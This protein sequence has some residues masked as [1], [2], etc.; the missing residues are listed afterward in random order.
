MLTSL[1][2]AK[3][4]FPQVRSNLVARPRLVQILEKGL[5]GPLTLISAPAGSGKTTLMGEWRTHSEHTT[6]I[7]WL[8]LDSAENDLHRFLTYLT[9][10][11]QS[12]AST[13]TLPTNDLL[14]S[15]QPPPPD[16][17]AALLLEAL[18]TLDTDLVLALDDYH[19]ISNITIHE[20]LNKLLECAPPV[21]HLVILTRSDPPLPL[22]R[23]R[24]RNQ[25]TEIRAH[26]LRFT[27]D[28]SAE[29][30]SHIMGLS[31][32]S[33]QVAL[34][35]ERTEGWIAG[36]QLA[37]LS[38]RGREDVDDFV[39]AFAGSNRFVVDYLIEEVLSLQSEKTREFLLKTS[40]LERMSASLCN[41]LTGGSDGQSVLEELERAN[42]FVVNLGGDGQWYRYHHLFADLLRNR[43][44]AGHPEM[45]RTLH[46]HAVVWFDDHKLINEAIEHAFE[47]ENYEAVRQLMR[48][49]FPDWWRVENRVRVLQWFEKFP[50]DFLSNEPWLCVVQAWTMW[51]QGK[52]DKTEAILDRAQQ[53]VTR[54]QTAGQFPVGDLEYDGL[55]AEI[56]AF[57]ALIATQRNDSQVVINLAKDALA[58]APAK[59]ATVRAVAYNALQVVYRNINEMDKAIEVC[60]L[61]LAESLKGGQ[62]GTIVTTYNL[63]G[64]MLV[65]QGQLHRAAVVYKEALDYSEKLS[66]ADEPA[67]AI[68][69]LR[70]ADLYYQWNY[71][72][73]AVGLIDAGLKHADKVGD[74]WSM[75]YGRYLKALVFIARYD[76][77][78]SLKIC[79]EIIKL[80]PKS[81][82]AYYAEDL[83]HLLLF[84]KAKLGLQDEQALELQSLP[85]N[86]DISTTEIEKL[87]FRVRAKIIYNRFEQLSELLSSLE[88]ITSQKKH[89]YWLIQVYI[90]QAVM[91]KRDGNAQSAIS[92]LKKSL[93]L[94]EPEGYMRVFLDEGPQIRDLL[95]TINLES[96]E[97]A[98][99]EYIQRLLVAFDTQTTSNTSAQQ[100]LPALLSERELEVLNLIASGASNK[101]I[102]SELVIAIGTVKRHTVNIFNKLGVENRTQAVAKARE[103]KLI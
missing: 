53:A 74:L 57:K 31:L 49:Y 65:I 10:S 17:I 61:G 36:L 41:A 48:K 94:A 86:E 99:N 18:N 6:P 14:K 5:Q 51:G 63:L 42:L 76:Q 13:L 7:A 38:M 92:Y 93:V 80:L 55:P 83:K 26:D 71:L 20:T 24:V 96:K 87:L 95:M 77:Q 75:I 52:V 9:T 39:T 1:L 72:D 45:V 100:T 78:G 28:E 25:L 98:L 70:L 37:A 73:E 50:V 47:A 60:E 43:L 69:Y 62:I 84:I 58:L 34:M 101:K 82:G 4:H 2:A 15:S 32:S 66:K 21:F 33:E 35:E 59:A 90:L 89:Y 11:M 23:L 16:V 91:E 44:Q 30:L 8:S 79:Q 40:I 68:I 97:N 3:L 64:G 67:F 22:A 81:R 56:L 12:A 88:S 103:L 19:V 102:A 46:Q 85:D 29:F 27:L 54:L